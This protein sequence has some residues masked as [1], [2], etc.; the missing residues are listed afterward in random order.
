MEKSNLRGRL[1]RQRILDIILIERLG[2]VG[3]K[4]R[5]GQ[6]D[7]LSQENARSGGKLEMLQH[8]VAVIFRRTLQRGGIEPA[9]TAD[10]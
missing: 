2:R 9:D 6:A 4:W 10:R 7:D 8:I 1:T 3:E 5:R